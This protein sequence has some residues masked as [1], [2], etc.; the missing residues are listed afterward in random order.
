M[1]ETTKSSRLNN[2]SKTN[3]LSR[4]EMK[5]TKG[6]ENKPSKNRWFKFSFGPD[7]C[8]GKMPH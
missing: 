6:G 2:V 8:D 1:K 3:E 5:Q 7:P 4:E